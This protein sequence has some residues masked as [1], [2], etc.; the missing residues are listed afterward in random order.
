MASKTD[1]IEKD[2]MEAIKRAA[3]PK[4][5]PFDEEAEVVRIDGDIAWVHFAGGVP[6]TPVKMTIDCKK[7]DM[8]QVHVAS[9]G[10]F[11]VG[12]A[13][14]PPTD[15]TKA[16]VAD[17]KADKAKVIAIDAKE[18]AE[19]ANHFA[20]IA[21]AA[22]DEAEVSASEA[23]ESAENASE[24]AA[25]ALG[26]LSTVQSVS[27]TLNWITQHG[28]MTL[29]SDV[30]LDPTHVYFVVDAG[31]DYTVGGTTY[32]IVTEPDVADISTYYELS[33]DESLN[34]YVGT[35]LA[36]DSEGLWLLPASSIIN[37]VLIATGAGTTYTT[38]GTYIIDDF[39]N[40]VAMFG[41]NSTIGISDGTQSYLYEDY[42]SLQMVD[43]EGRTYFHV[44]DLRDTDGNLTVTETFTGDGSTVYF[45]VSFSLYSIGTVTVNGTTVTPQSVVSSTVMIS[46]APAS[47]SEI[48]ITY[49]TKSQLAK[50]FTLGFRR[51]GTVGV[52]SFAEGY[53]VVSSGNFAHAEG[54]NSTASGDMSHAEGK[55]TTASGYVSHSEGE[56]TKARG[57]NSHAE[58]YEAI[59]SGQYSHAEGAWTTASGKASH[60]EGGDSVASGELSHAQNMSIASKEAQTSLG[61]FNVEDTAST[62]THPSGRTAYGEYAVI[63]GNGTADNAR[64]NALTVDWNGDVFMALDT[65]AQSGTTDGD[66]YDAIT[67]LGWGSD[68]IV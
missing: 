59:A 14:S 15:D 9:D 32:A 53:D 67:A 12:N 38:A 7:G 62:T 33:I 39:G 58:G 63:V 49:V 18:L 20:G 30:A 17:K 23:K 24:Y 29:T 47:G 68:V 16:T 66:L 51:T 42:H 41:K 10:A 52:F 5:M 21:K 25:R 35:H 3:E 4:T 60:A 46:P 31:G 6:E 1:K 45:D 43:K 34:N 57:I 44:S 2:L 56:N 48:K 13:T 8:V 50:A 11:L 19:S 64:S 65:T 27:E 36:L 28:T 61:T 26:N 37:K 22:A 54:H 55:Q 40:T